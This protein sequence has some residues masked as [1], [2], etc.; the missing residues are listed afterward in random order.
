MNHKR[1]L[2]ALAE[3]I[4]TARVLHAFVQEQR[5]LLEQRRRLQIPRLRLRVRCGTPGVPAS[6]LAGTRPCHGLRK[7]KR[8]ITSAVAR[9][10]RKSR[11]S[12]ATRRS[13]KRSC[14]VRATYKMIFEENTAFMH[15]CHGW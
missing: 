13:A 14:F 8:R 5:G 10:A 12:F 6:E 4:H 11:F 7:A 9:S 1:E 2:H 15:A 3:P